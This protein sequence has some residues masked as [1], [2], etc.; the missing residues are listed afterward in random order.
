MH[1]FSDVISYFSLKSWKFNDNN[2]RSLIQKLS[3]LDQTLFS[4]DLNK[5]SWDEYFK[6]HVLGIRMYIIKDPLETLPEGRKRN[7]KS[8]THINLFT[9]SWLSINILFMLFYFQI[10]HSLLHII[11]LLSCSIIINSVW[12][13]Q[14]IC[15]TKLLLTPGIS[16]SYCIDN[17]YKYN[18]FRSST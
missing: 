4:F 18:H 17:F 10:M 13:L 12:T 2:T 1:K 5:L 16:S 3:K 6:K 11:I 14:F 9:V 8:V 15:L 7:Q